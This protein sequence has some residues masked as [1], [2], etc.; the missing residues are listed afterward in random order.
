MPDSDAFR[1]AFWWINDALPYASA[2]LAG[3]FLAIDHTSSLSV[4][5]NRIIAAPR[6]RTS[7]QGAMAGTLVAFRVRHVSFSRLSAS[8]YVLRSLR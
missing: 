7:Q 2:H 5:D 1:S 3:R 8:F 6:Q 4:G